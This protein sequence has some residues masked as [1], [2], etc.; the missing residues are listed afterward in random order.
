MVSRR[1]GAV[2]RTQFNFVFVNKIMDEVKLLDIA[3]K[4]K[5]G[6][7]MD[8]IHGYG[9]HTLCMSIRS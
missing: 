4:R 8:I 5:N 9:F 3:R 2:K 1:F 6:E 7:H